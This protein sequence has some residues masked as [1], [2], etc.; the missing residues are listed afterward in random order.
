M[1]EFRGVTCVIGDAVAA[2]MRELRPGDTETKRAFYCAQRCVD[3]IYELTK[4]CASAPSVGC[5]SV[6]CALAA[7]QD[8][9]PCRIPSCNA[10]VFDKLHA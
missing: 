4:R 7:C 3:L 6:G 5:T 10:A 1:L 2:G 8:V 9:S